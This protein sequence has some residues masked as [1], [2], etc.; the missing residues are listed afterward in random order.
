VVLLVEP[1]LPR[2]AVTACAGQLLRCV[3]GASSEVVTA[4]TEHAVLV[5]AVAAVPIVVAARLPGAPVALLA[6]R[7]VHAAAAVV[8]R[9]PVL[10]SPP[11]RALEPV[12]ADGRVVHAAQALRSFGAVEPTVFV[13]GPARVYVFSAG[14]GD[15]KAVGALALNV[16]DALGDGG[17]LGR[18]RAVVF[19]RG[20]EHTLVRPLA[21]SAGVLAATGVVTQP[22][23]LLRDADRAATLLEAI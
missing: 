3:A 17:D 18:P 10:P 7:A 15:D 20:G 13:D 23:R 11:R 16:C 1:S 2:E 8:D 4:R 12:G 5:L 22:G 14:G 19:R 21:G 9:A 6:L